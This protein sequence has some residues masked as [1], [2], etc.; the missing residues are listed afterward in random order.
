M[1]G[2][3]GLADAVE[4]ATAVPVVTLAQ[5]A[6]THALHDGIGKN[7]ATRLLQVVGGDIGQ[8]DDLMPHAGLLVLIRQHGVDQV[9]EHLANLVLLG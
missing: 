1:L 4:G 2:Q 3:A 6:Q 8:V 5:H 7:R 9:V